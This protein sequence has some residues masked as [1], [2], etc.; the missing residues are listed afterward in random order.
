MPTRADGRRIGHC[1]ADQAITFQLDQLLH[2]AVVVCTD[3]RHIGHI[4]GLELLN[5]RI[6]DARCPDAVDLLGGDQVKRLLCAG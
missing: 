2:E 1:R 3:N 4:G 5:H 6:V